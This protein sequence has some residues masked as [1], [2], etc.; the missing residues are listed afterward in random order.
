MSRVRT[1]PTKKANGKMKATMP[2]VTLVPCSLRITKTLAMHGT[3]S[4]MT[5]M[6]TRIWLPLRIRCAPGRRL[7]QEDRPV[8]A[9]QETDQEGIRRSR[10]KAEPSLDEGRRQVADAREDPRAVEHEEDQRPQDEERKDLAEIPLDARERL[11]D[12][13][14]E[15][16][17]PDRRNLEQEVGRLSAEDPATRA[18]P[19]RS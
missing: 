3:K 16:G 9:A 8:V 7:Q 11:H 15:D 17:P 18:I 10:R 14:S 1:P 6:L 4:V 19:R 5:T 2:A 12:D 13:V